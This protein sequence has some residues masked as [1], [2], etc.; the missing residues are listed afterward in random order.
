MHHKLLMP[1]SVFWF[2]WQT[3]LLDPY[4]LSE[5][6]EPVLF[7]LLI[8]PSMTQ[9]RYTFWQFWEV[10]GRFFSPVLLNR[11]LLVSFLLWESLFP[12]D[13]FTKCKSSCLN[14]K[15]YWKLTYVSGVQAL[16]AP[17][18]SRW[19]SENEGYG[20][21]KKSSYQIWLTSDMYWLFLRLASWPW[22][23]TSF[24]Y[25]DCWYRVC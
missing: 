23:S 14:Q 22:F 2:A 16:F 21:N 9:M 15:Y 7:F 24:L 19:I 20:V 10:I 17:L 12:V 25:F 11:L 13:K 1:F 4:I 3:F 18:F 5:L 8:L 6:K